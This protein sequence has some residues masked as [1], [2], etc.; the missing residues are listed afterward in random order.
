MGGERP[1]LVEQPAG[2]SSKGTNAAEQRRGC[3]IEPEKGTLKLSGSEPGALVPHVENEQIAVDAKSVDVTL[4]GPL[5]K[6][7]GAHSAYT[8]TDVTSGRIPFD[9]IQ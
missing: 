4:T 1:A 7:N 6:A 8:W 5:V 2:T 3:V 9:L